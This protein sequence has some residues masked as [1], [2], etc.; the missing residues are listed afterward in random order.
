PRELLGGIVRERDAGPLA[1]ILEQVLA[2]GLEPQLA[3][4]A[5]AQLARDP[6]N[7]LQRLV[8]ALRD[9]LIDRAHWFRSAPTLGA[10]GPAPGQVELQGGERLAQFVVNLTRDAG[11]LLLADRLQPGRERP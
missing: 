10:L 2:G 3:A 6:A 5:G 8:D 9:R 1:R 4:H 7:D 11:A